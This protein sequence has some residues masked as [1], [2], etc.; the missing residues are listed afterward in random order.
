MY[1]PQT[2]I[3][4]FGPFEKWGINVVG[5]LPRTNSGKEYIIVGVD[6]LTRSAEAK[7]TSRVTKEEVVSFIF[8]HICCRFGVPLE[9]TSQTEDLASELTCSMN[10]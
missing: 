1:E 5:L 4:A 7:A 2:P 3:K 9:I 6:Y 8:E 10:L